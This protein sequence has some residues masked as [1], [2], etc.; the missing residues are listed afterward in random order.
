MALSRSFLKGM[1]LTEEQV[2]AIIEAHSETINGLRDTNKSLETQL[3]E[4]LENAKKTNEDEVNEYKSKYE[5]E[6]SDFEEYKNSLEKEKEVNKKKLAYGEVLKEA[7]VSDKRV[8]QILKLANVDELK[9]D[10]NGQLLEK[11]SLTKKIKEDWSEFIP[12]ISINGEKVSNPPQNNGSKLTKEEIFKIKDTAK[13]QKAIAE[14]I[15][16]FK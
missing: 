16:L 6:H 11:E 5:K 13:R 1:G 2:G 12:N 8:E 10:D 14:N 9:L 7:G 15:D 4:A 3:A